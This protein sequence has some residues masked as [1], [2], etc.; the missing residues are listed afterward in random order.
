MATY[1]YGHRYPYL[2]IVAQRYDSFDDCPEI[3]ATGE[4]LEF[5]SVRERLHEDAGE[6]C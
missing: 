6:G 5:T 2:G 1:T 3:L 4:D